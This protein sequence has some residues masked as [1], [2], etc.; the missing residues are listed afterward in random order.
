MTKKQTLSSKD[1]FIQPHFFKKSG[2]GFT[3]IELLVVVSIIGLL[4]SIVL[5]ALASG[6]QKAR[7]AKRLSDITQMNNV[8]ELYFAT[9][10][11]YPVD[12]TPQD[13]IPD[14]VIPTFAVAVA[15]APIPSDGPCIGQTHSGAANNPPAG[16][17]YNTYY[18]VPTGT[19]YSVAGVTVYPSFNYFFCLGNVTGSF[20]SGLRTLTPTGVQ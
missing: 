2:A 3:L 16:T 13:G 1:G 8:L 14:S 20:N 18:Y 12:T 6:R 19:A 9:N 5:V 10:K 7:D 17:Q 11:G 4:A 15:A